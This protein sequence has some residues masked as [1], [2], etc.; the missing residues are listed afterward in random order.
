MKIHEDSR[1]TCTNAVILG[2]RNSGHL[3]LWE[4]SSRK[5]QNRTL[6][7]LQ[8]Q[9]GRSVKGK[10]HL[11]TGRDHP[12]VENR[13]SS[14]LSLTSALD[15]VGGQRH[16]PAALPP[17][18]TRYPL[19]RVGTRCGESRPHQDSNPGPSSP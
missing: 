1:D 5:P 10:V 3:K 12:E 9:Y 2:L 11:I 16:A 14:T 19:Y 13:Y 17:R 7:E 8:G 15:G 18:K 6:S 4:F